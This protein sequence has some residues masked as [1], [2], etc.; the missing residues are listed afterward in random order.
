M[1]EHWAV[2]PSGCD[3]G[4]LGCGTIGLWE[5]WD[6]PH[7]HIHKAC[8]HEFCARFCGEIV[9]QNRVCVV[10]VIPGSRGDSGD[11]GTPDRCKCSQLRFQD[12]YTRLGDTAMV[13]TVRILQQHAGLSVCLSVSVHHI[14]CLSACLPVC[15]SIYLCPYIWSICMFIPPHVYLS[16]CMCDGRCMW[17]KGSSRC[18]D[19]P[20]RM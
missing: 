10:Y 7:T 17:W 5:H 6:D 4:T 19:S 14:T 2:G 9:S 1:W 3:V 11:I 20:M 12:P 18:R 8:Y 16:T 13:P 15:L